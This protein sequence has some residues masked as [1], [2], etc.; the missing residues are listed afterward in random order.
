M[1]KLVIEGGQK[2]RGEISVSGSKNATLP[3]L[4]AT[5]LTD[6][7]CVIHNVPRLRDT[8]TMIKLLRSLG[9]SAVLEGDK[10]IVS[11]P[12][13]SYVADYKLVSTMR[14]SFC[15]FG[16]LL[17]KF[18]QAS[19]SLPGGCVIGIRPVDLHIK[20]VMGLGA[21]IHVESGYVH[22]KANKLKGTYIY[23]GG[24]FGSS[25]LATANVMMAATLASGVTIIDSA[26]CEPEVVDLGNF[27]N[28]MGA[29]VMGHGTPQI[30]VRGVKS[31]HGAEYKIGPD[32]IE[33]GT[34]VLMAAATKSDITIKNLNPTHIMALLH[35]VQEAGVSYKQ[36][37]HTVKITS[38]KNLK[39]VSLTTY[40]YPG[41]PTDLQAQFMA[42]MATTPGV[43]VITEK[44]FPDRF[45]HI[46][47]LNRMGAKIRREG[48]SAII[49]GVK[50]LYGAPVMASDLRAS[51]ALVIAGLA[52]KGRTE[53]HRIYHLERGY[54]NMDEKLRGLGAK[55]WKE[56]E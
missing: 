41:F 51:A 50:S 30:T 18:R 45:I 42:L 8:L 1:E 38:R 28:A 37:G 44:V 49:E 39:P 19:V 11:K 10:V 13:T 46:A 20:G 48:Y 16:P 32:R 35:H 12:T 34:Y 15:V 3:V 53:I 22:A 4:A 40:P 26:A 29:E 24:T 5:L 55:V 43:S 36:K 56:K 23:L 14:G 33:A 27:L 47:E 52:A 7:P 17:A 25:V 9:K 2:L 21:K 6:K 31:L 54:E